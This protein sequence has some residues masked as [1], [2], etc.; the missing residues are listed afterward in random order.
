MKKQP[1]INSSNATIHSVNPTLGTF[2]YTIWGS[3]QFE[4][5]AANA[6][7]AE[8]IVSEKLKLENINYSIRVDDD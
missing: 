5:E 2:M 3:F 7:D 4:V 1:V 8:D 6:S